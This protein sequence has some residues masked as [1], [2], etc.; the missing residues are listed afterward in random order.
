MHS[1][2][3][4]AFFITLKTMDNITI[5]SLIC[6]LAVAYIY[7]CC[8]FNNYKTC[9]KKQSPKIYLSGPITGVKQAEYNFMIAEQ[10]IEKNTGLVPVS[11]FKNGLPNSASYEEHMKADIKMLEGCDSIALLPGWR[12]SDGAR[13]E[14]ER[15]MELELPIFLLNTY[16][17]GLYII[18]GPL[19]YSYLKDVS[20]S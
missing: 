3:A 5:A 12:H 11:P 10:F 1:V 20:E 18:N 7:L 4:C 14:L 19:P 15:A 17:K 8:V 13:R 16:Y 9:M 6:C 2:F